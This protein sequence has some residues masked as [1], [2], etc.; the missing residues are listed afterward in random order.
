MNAST[1]S[2]LSVKGLL[3]LL[4]LGLL[5]SPLCGQA[6]TSTKICGQ[7]SDAL[8]EAIR[9][10]DALAASSAIA[11][12]QLPKTSPPSKQINAPAMA[13]GAAT[14][15]VNGA[16]F[17]GI[18][19]F[20]MDNGLLSQQG[21]LV[22]GDFNLFD[23]KAIFRPEVLD[24]QTLYQSQGNENLRRWGIGLTFGGKGDSFDRDGDGV[25]DPALEAKNL[26]DIVNWELRFRLA[27]TRDR[28]DWTN[29]KKFRDDRAV[30]ASFTNVDQKSVDLLTRFASRLKP[31]A[32]KLDNAPDHCVDR[33]EFDDFL[34]DP[35][36]V[37]MIA[38][39]R[40]DEAVLD[41]ALETLNEEI[42]NS[43]IVTAFVGGLE[44]KDEFGPS[45]HSAGI[46]V[47]KGVVKDQGIT[48]NAEYMQT[49]SLLRNVS[50]PT[51]LKL[52]LEYG[53][54]LLKGTT[55]GGQNGVHVALSGAYEKYKDV[56]DA[57]HDT[58]AKLNAKLELHVTDTVKIPLSIT[59]ANHAD[60]LS[61]ERD[62]RGH[63]GFSIDLTNPLQ[64]KT[65]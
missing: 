10:S 62:I 57:M 51:T 13:G 2:R 45:K 6:Q 39:I 58:V 60:L 28:R 3:L 53:L 49:R 31:I 59:W 26:G 20:A 14:T 55:I 41:P 43:L 32:I 40:A 24:R 9:G 48:F 61:N 5:L 44:R 54:L 22:T 11:A 36:V 8:Q 33:S 4:L 47:A 25:T 63:I 29:V 50:D 46:R 34:K 56:P 65:N 17:P 23:L 42:D 1:P 52:G 16:D 30:S 7:L 38:E 12:D 35:E 21:D 18:L 27:G 19:A 64:P 37:K 15:L